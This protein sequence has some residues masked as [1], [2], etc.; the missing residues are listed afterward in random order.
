MNAVLHFLQH[1]LNRFEM[2]RARWQLEQAELKVSYFHVVILFSSFLGENKVLEWRAKRPG[3]AQE[4]SCQE[5]QNVGIQ[6]EAGEVCQCGEKRKRHI[7]VFR[8]KLQRLKGELK[9]E[10]QVGDEGLNVTGILV[11]NMT[12]LLPTSS[13]ESFAP[14]EVDATVPSIQSSQ[15]YTKART[16]LRTYLEEIGY[17]EKVLDVRSFRVKSLLGLMS[18]NENGGNEGFV[19][20]VSRD[21][22]SYLFQGHQE[23]I[24]STSSGRKR[25]GNFGCSRRNSR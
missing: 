9:P 25:T 4:G 24:S 19:N 14:I 3:R 6:F 10:Q 22:S 16:M 1:E 17:S 12:R 7:V 11:D 21:G 23:Q 5:N 8:T 20:V 15:I 18:E 13:E 2:E